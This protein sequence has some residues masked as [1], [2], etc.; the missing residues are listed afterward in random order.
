MENKN[1]A[2]VY[3]HI[4]PKFILN[5]FAANMQSGNKMIRKV[6]I[7]SDKTKL[8][9]FPETS[10]CFG[11]DRLYWDESNE[12]KSKLER[13]LGTKLESGI[14]KLLKDK[15]LSAGETVQLSRAELTNLKRYMLAQLIR[16]PDANYDYWFGTKEMQEVWSDFAKS[17]GRQKQFRDFSNLSQHDAMLH[18][19][20]ILV[21]NKF[22]EILEHDD[23]TPHLAK[24]LLLMNSGYLGF[25]QAFEKNDYVLTDT[26]LVN[27]RDVMIPTI[28]PLGVVPIYAKQSMLVDILKKFENEI[29]LGSISRDLMQLVSL[30]SILINFMK[31]FGFSQFQ[32]IK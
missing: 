7:Y 19:L 21:E 12:D 2:Y 24:L 27:E 16:I 22:D 29:K 17:L 11:E 25:W 28:T 9:D 31:T 5:N 30:Q 32:T 13:D 8:I 23:C 14:S 15:V 6:W 26:Y 20:K 4:I 10:K 3:N 1:K 18:E